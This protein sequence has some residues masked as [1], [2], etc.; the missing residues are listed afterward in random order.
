MQYQNGKRYRTMSQYCVEKYGG[1]IVKI[2][3][4][5]GATCPNRDGLK[6]FGGCSFCSGDGGGEFAPKQPIPLLDQY[7]DGINLNLKWPD[8]VKVGYF[9]SFSNTYMPIEQLEAMLAQTVQLPDIGG[10]RIATRADCIDEQKADLL[11]KYA[12]QIPVEVELGLQTIHE[13]TS[14]IIN[15]CHSL[16]EWQAGFT[17]LKQRGIYVCAHLINGL[18]GESAEM[19]LQS[20]KWLAKQRVDGVKLHMLHVIRG[21][22]L[23]AQYQN[24]PFELLS[25]E[26]YVEIVCQQIR[27]FH[28][29]TV[30]E[31]LT[32]DGAKSTLI[33]PTWT[34][35]KRNVLN[36]ID[37]RLSQL[38][39]WQGDR[40]EG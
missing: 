17:L 21:S 39:A 22:Q 15:R 4:C 2:P 36:S 18:P 14:E 20:A 30:I 32:G 16:E 33:A 7:Q 38:D 34:L 26:Q 40:F 31:R 35:N 37:K 13:Q 27:V 28:P 23:A 5:S 19:M 1:R 11:A 12:E 8:A 24:Q 29:E 3:L 10:I 25:L 6:G 9:Q